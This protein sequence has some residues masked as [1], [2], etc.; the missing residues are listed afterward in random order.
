MT[1]AERLE[2]LTGIPARKF[3]RVLSLP[4]RVKRPN[5]A[6]EKARM[7]YNAEALD[8]PERPVLLKKWTDLCYIEIA[9]VTTTAEAREAYKNTPGGSDVRRAALERW[10]ELSWIEVNNASNADEAWSAFDSSPL[11]TEVRRAACHKWLILCKTFEEAVQAY[12]GTTEGSYGEKLTLRKIY[13]MYHPC[14]A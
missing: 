6:I 11:H 2:A 4:A 5:S 8:S 9:R 7:E 12:H 3:E 13:D 10:K 1:V 14:E